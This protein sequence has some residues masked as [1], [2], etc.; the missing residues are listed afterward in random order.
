MDIEPGFIHTLF[1][2]P[3]T[4]QEIELATGWLNFL[5][6]EAFEEESDAIR[7]YHP[8]QDI[9]SQ[10]KEDLLAQASWLDKNRIL[11]GTIINENWNRKWESSFDPVLVDNFCLIKTSFHS[12]ES[13]AEHVIVIDPEMA[14]GTGHHNTTFLMI[15]MMS[16][17]EF[18]G[19]TVLDFG[20]GTGVLAIL[21]EK[22]GAHRALAIDYD[23]KATD[24]AIQNV[25]KNDC[26]LIDCQSA[27]ISDVAENKKFNIILANVN[28][29]VL[30]HSCHELSIRQEAGGILVL[31]GL[32]VE[33][34]ELIKATYLAEGYQ[35]EKT[36]EK[37][38]WCCLKFK[39]LP[40]TQIDQ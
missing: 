11:T 35:L 37:G 8:D 13:P 22:M 39:F 15:Q 3:L 7:I 33:D 9:L 19:K 23:Q 31:S 1:I 27:E 18:A 26:R 20:T 25:Q 38:D 2:S 24:C 17:M 21:A 10:L 16:E 29:N 12:V 40:I 6:V 36:L 28:R 34:L 14:F 5:E 4:T 30:L 32:L